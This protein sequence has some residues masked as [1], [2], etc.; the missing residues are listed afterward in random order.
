MFWLAGPPK[1]YRYI[2]FLKLTNN[3]YI[4]QFTKYF[5]KKGRKKEGWVNSKGKKGGEGETPALKNPKMVYW[6]LKRAEF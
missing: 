5:L 2:L 6:K 4:T 1:F 3:E